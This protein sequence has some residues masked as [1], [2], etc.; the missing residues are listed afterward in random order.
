[1]P[2]SDGRGSASLSVSKQWHDRLCGEDGCKDPIHAEGRCVTH[3]KLWRAHWVDICPW[4]CNDSWRAADLGY[5]EA[6]A[7]YERNR[8][9]WIADPRSV[10]EPG[11][12]GRPDFSPWSGDPVFCGHCSGGVRSR[13]M[14]ISDLAAE[15][16]AENLG[17]RKRPENER[18]SGS[19]HKSSPSATGD[20]LEALGRL[21]RDWEG[22]ARRG[23]TP[24]RRGYLD[25]EIGTVCANLATGCFPL[26][27]NRRETAVDFA[28]DVH[29]WHR[30][31]R[32]A[33][34]TGTGRHQKN[35]PCP[36]CDRYSLVWVEGDDH[37][38]CQTPSCGR[39]MLL[40]DYETYDALFPHFADSPGAA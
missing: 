23:F 37:V 28:A 31:L 27:M 34:R 21:L 16:A 25:T 9:A 11:L 2:P 17:L 35:R 24:P 7:A 14:E 30:R 18:V 6:I 20:D 40:S 5:R 26:L 10:P 39:L 3:Y 38:A 15:A 1:L 32:D 12:P 36:R 19:R 13:L 8:E 33:T 22:T 4:R 29:D